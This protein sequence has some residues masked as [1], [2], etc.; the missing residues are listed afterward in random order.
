MQEFCYNVYKLKVEKE[1]WKIGVS[2]G[3]VIEIKS[4]DFAVRI[5]KLYKFLCEQKKEY[6]FSK[7]L[8][9][10]GTSIGANIAEAQQAQSKSDFVSKISISLKETSETKY[11]INLLKAT[12]YL[13]EAESISILADCVEIEKILVSILKSSKDNM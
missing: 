10:A 8:L 9:R 2:M 6:V 5:V 7:Q 1:K 13:T 3:N 11:W 12:D 4:F